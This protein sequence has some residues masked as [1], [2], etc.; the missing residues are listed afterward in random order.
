[1]TRTL[2]VF[3]SRTGYTRRVAKLVARKLEADVEE[4]RIVQPIGGPLGYAFC[5]M[6]AIAGLTPALRPS[7]HDPAGYDTVIVGTPVWFWSLSSPVRSWLT[8]HRIGRARVGFFCTIGG[9]GA[10]GVFATMAA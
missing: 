3:H 10:A 7:R 8:E 4:I 1:M 5:A 9:S 6:E 2:V